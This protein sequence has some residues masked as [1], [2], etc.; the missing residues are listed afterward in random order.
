MEKHE[1]RPHQYPALHSP[2]HE[3]EVR[4]LPVKP[5]VPAL[6]RPLQV[7]AV[8]PAEPHRPQ[9]HRPLHVAAVCAVALPKYPALHCPEQAEVVRAVAA[10]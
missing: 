9:A 3:A 4:T 8:C 10:P 1:P 6:H 2:V 5:Y 7:E